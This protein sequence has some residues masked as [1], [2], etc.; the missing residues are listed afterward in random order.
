MLNPSHDFNNIAV[1]YFYDLPLSIRILL[2]SIGITNDSDSSL[3][4]YLLFEKRFCQHLIQLGFEDTM[5]K[6]LKFAHFCRYKIA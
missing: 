2:R 5:A 1:D 4:S 3:V 6:K